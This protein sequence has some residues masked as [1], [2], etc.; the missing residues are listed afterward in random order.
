VVEG[1]RRIYAIQDGGF[2]ERFASVNGEL[3]WTLEQEKRGLWRVGVVV[4]VAI[5]GLVT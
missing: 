1:R 3:A 5:A 2:A 4:G